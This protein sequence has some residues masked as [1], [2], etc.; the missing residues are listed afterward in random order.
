MTFHSCSTLKL[1]G[2]LRVDD[3]LI[4]VHSKAQ[5]WQASNVTHNFVVGQ[6]RKLAGNSSDVRTQEPN[7]VFN[8]LALA[9]WKGSKK[10]F[11]TVKICD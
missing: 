2:V 1:P 11:S 7:G 6:A 9:R 4:H 5:I 3:T 8:H 10:H